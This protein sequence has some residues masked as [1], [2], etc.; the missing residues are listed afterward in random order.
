MRAL[1]QGL[2]ARVRA[3]GANLSGGQ[4]QRLTI[5]RGLL[6]GKPLWLLD[7]AT[8][9]IDAKSEREITLRLTAACRERGTVLIA[10]TH[11]LQ[12]LD[13]YDEVWFVEGG[14]VTHRGPHRALMREPRYRTFCADAGGDES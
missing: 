3:I 12:W 14:A 13:A 5:A 11:R 1:P 9:A 8:S 10:V 6:R 4:L 7:E 2:A